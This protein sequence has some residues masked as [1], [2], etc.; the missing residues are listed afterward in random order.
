MKLRTFWLIIV[1]TLIVLGAGWALVLAL[2]GQ[3]EP[4]TKFI[5]WALGGIV[6][7]ALVIWFLGGLDR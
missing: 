5:S 6:T 3:L 1:L 7:L 2:N 4:A